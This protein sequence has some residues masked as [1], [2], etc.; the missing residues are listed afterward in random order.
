MVE[1][2]RFQGSL[3]LLLYLIRSQD[4]DIFDIPIAQITRQFLDVLAD[5]L[6]RLDLDR[7]GEFLELAATLIRLKARFLLPRPQTEWE[8]DPR[9]ELVRRLLEYELYQ[10]VSRILRANEYE[11]RRHMPKGYFPEPEIPRKEPEA[12]E[13]ATTWDDLLEA[14]LGIR[15]PDPLT[16]HVA[17]V[18]L[19]SSAEKVELIRKLLA[20]QDRLPFRRMFPEWDDRPHVVAAL[21][22]C[23]E[24]AHQQFLRLEQ[25]RRFGSIWISAQA[26]ET[27]T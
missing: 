3:D 6:D 12:E 1:I 4:I 26:K 20:E 13:L 8:E 11:R 21:L 16:A 9:A 27:S 25:A 19:V 24:L 10:D 17:P 7:S 22:A 18:R 14:A 23:L 5:G 2:D 15:E